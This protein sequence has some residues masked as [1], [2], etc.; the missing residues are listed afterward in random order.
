MRIE[1][2]NAPGQPA[3]AWGEAGVDLFL[4][5]LALFFS[6]QR[7]HQHAGLKTVADADLPSFFHQLFHEDVRDLIEEIE[8]LD[9]QARLAAIEK[10]TDGSGAHGALEIGVVADDH[11][12][13][14]A[15]FQSHVL[16]IF[17]R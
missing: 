2:I 3:Q 9:C 15:Q 7:A 1:L 11:R 14:A 4:D 5:F 6:V 8:P 16:K 10:T 13:A 17:R 12:I